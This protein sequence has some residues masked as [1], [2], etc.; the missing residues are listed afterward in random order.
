[1]PVPMAIGFVWKKAQFTDPAIA[2]TLFY[3]PIL[4]FT[5]GGHLPVVFAKRTQFGTAVKAQLVAYLACLSR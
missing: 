3:R 1:M 4:G 2:S 5:G